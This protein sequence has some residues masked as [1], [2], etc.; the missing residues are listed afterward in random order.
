MA[1]TPEAASVLIVDDSLI[2]LR[3]ARLML[4]QTSVTP[5]C[6]EDGEAAL[7][8]LEN[9]Y[10][11]LILMDVQM[12]G[13]DGLETTRRIR[14]MEFARGQPAIV[15]VTA[16]ASMENR[17]RCLEAGMD[18]FLPKPVRAE[19]LRSLVSHYVD[20]AGKPVRSGT[21]APMQVDV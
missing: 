8:A 6:A 17:T 18:A 19:V 13:I 20:E 10:F 16:N 2:N 15:A 14:R 4:L 9:T 11:P 7:L 5:V 3:V 12:P 21:A 1:R